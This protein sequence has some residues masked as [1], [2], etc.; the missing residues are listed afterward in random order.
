LQQRGE[1]C[2]PINNRDM[3]KWHRAPS[4]NTLAF[5]Q[6]LDDQERAT[7]AGSIPGVTHNS[8]VLLK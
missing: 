3:T 5:D 8:A 4:L 7:L 1:R 2:G 6:A